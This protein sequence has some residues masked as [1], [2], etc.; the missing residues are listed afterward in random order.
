MRKTI[1]LT[2]YL[3][4][5]IISAY[6]QDRYELNTGW[7]CMPSSKVKDKGERISTTSYTISKW[8]NAIIPGTVLTTQL[9]NK[10]IPDPFFGMNN[11]KIPDIYDTGRDFYTYW[12]VKD[13]EE[14]TPSEDDQV[15]LTFR[16][17]NYSCEIFLNGKKVNNETYKGMF[18]RKTF[19]ITQL[20]AK[21]G[22]NRLAVIVYPPD[23]VGKPNGGQGG[24]GRIAKNVS[25]QYV[26]G[27]DWIQPIRDRNT[28]IWDKV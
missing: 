9:A 4:A 11:E 17:I 19:N 24:D 13:F 7:K 28:G 25:H 15:W 21:N 20:L 16:G 26:A 6:A 18:L 5:F 12:F 10:E 8:Q 3:I 14:K 23:P 2:F 22:K 27:W 1:I